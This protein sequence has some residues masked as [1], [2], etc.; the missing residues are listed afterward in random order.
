MPTEHNDIHHLKA[1]STGERLI[2]VIK[3]DGLFVENDCQAKG[4]CG[5]CKVKVIRGIAT[6]PLPEE[7]KILG[8]K[9]IEN[10]IRLACLC[11]VKGEVTIFL[12]QS[13]HHMQIQEQ[14]R[15]YDFDLD[16]IIKKRHFILKPEKNESLYGALCKKTNSKADNPLD[17]VKALGTNSNS[18]TAVCYRDR[19]IGIER[20]DTS[21]FCYGVALDIGT[22]TVAA[23]LVDLNTAGVLSTKS[24][25]NPQFAT[26]SD[27]LSRIYFAKQHPGHIHKLSKLIQAGVNELITA[28]FRCAGIHRKHC[29]LISVAG[30]TVMLHL[31][32]GVSPAALGYY[33]YRAVFVEEL[34]L[35]TAKVN[36][37][38]APFA[39]LQCLP[40]LSG[41]IGADITAG[42]SALDLMT[43]NRKIL[44]IDL[45]TNG[46]IVICRRGKIMAAS[47]AAGPALEGMNISCGIKATAGA[48]DQVALRDGKITFKTIGNG[49]PTGLC[50][51]GLLDLV[52]VLLKAGIIQPSG[53][54]VAPEKAALSGVTEIEGSRSFELLKFTPENKKSIHLTQK[55]IRQVQLAKGAL[56]TG[57]KLL[58]DRTELL[59][60]D[61]D[62]VY[63]AGGFGY[64]LNTETLITLG[65]F[66]K[67]W[68]KR[69]V[70]AGNTSLSGAR[71][72][73]LNQDLMRRHA[74]KLAAAADYDLN[75][76]PNFNSIFARSMTL[77]ESIF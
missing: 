53:R 25:L 31:F 11:R 43:S 62:T 48:I 18:I 9:E 55:D 60:S 2:D 30:N 46:E 37:K 58:L 73:L 45:G 66:P 38:A 21:D 77:G 13:E 44:F 12:P 50:G 6:G 5:K 51:S 67:I 41:F 22:T 4:T 52:A 1:D 23:E 39:M 75:Q 68:K 57:M 65:L 3:R 74:S 54:M 63:I 33:P 76:A 16:P 34:N 24:I 40:G 35:E 20:G 72:T 42:L 32:M 27:V 70:Y 28:L 19:L 36:I 47:T 14:G 26:G 59:P 15:L 29:Y 7:L 56:S 10:K 49:R 71:L 64:Y 61:I 69:L 17:I 8:K